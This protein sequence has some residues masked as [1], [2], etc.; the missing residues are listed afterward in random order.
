[1]IRLSPKQAAKRLREMRRKTDAPSVYASVTGALSPPLPYRRPLIG[2]TDFST[3]KTKET[4]AMTKIAI[5]GQR[6]G[7]PGCGR[8]MTIV[9]HGLCGKCYN[10]QRGDKPVAKVETIYEGKAAAAI[11]GFLKEHPEVA[12]SIFRVGEN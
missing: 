7:Y 12:V 11:P 3:R 8:K 5:C 6:E 4:E 1:M 10:A 9:G 2:V